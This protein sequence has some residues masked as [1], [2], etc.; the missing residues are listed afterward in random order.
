MRNPGYQGSKPA[1]LKASSIICSRLA[2]RYD[3]LSLKLDYHAFSCVFIS[4]LTISSSPAS[5][6]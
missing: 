4:W 2:L 6:S 5:G 3:E 1:S